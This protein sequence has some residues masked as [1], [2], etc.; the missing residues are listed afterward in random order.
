MDVMEKSR[1]AKAS[2]M[3]KV[4][5]DF[6][7]KFVWVN[8]M[9]QSSSEKRKTN[10]PGH[11]TARKKRGRTENLSPSY[12]AATSH[13]QDV[14]P[15]GVPILESRLSLNILYLVWKVKKINR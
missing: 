13:E 1:Q 2:Q 9:P 15:V 8:G 7:E 14:R 5:L 3:A 12:T 10:E 4:L 6:H 11:K